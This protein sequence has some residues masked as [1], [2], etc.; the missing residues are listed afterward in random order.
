MTED[1]FGRDWPVV[2]ELFENGSLEQ[3][4]S[5]PARV[6]VWLDE[7]VAKA[8]RETPSHGVR[9][10]TGSLKANENDLFLPADLPG[11]IEKLFE[12]STAPLEL[13]D[14]VQIIPGGEDIKNHPRWIDHIL[15]R[16]N[17]SNLDRRS[18]I[19]AI[20]GGALLDAVG[21]AAALAHRGIRLI[22]IPTT[23]LAQADSGVGV[24]NAVNW[25]NKK[26][27]KGTFAVPW[28]VVNDQEVLRQLPDRDFRCGFSE[29]VKVSLLKSP[30][31]FEFLNR[32]ATSIFERSMPAA[33]EAIRLSVLMHIDH[34]TRGGD[35]FEM[36]QARPLD[37]GHW[38]AHKLEAL[39]EYRIRHGEAVSIGVAVDVVY[40][41]L[42]HGLPDSIVQATLQTLTNLGLPIYHPALSEKNLFDGLEEFRQHLGGELTLT[43]LSEI[44]R[45]IAVHAV[46]HS[47]MRKAIQIVG[48]HHQSLPQRP[49]TSPASNNTS[50]LRI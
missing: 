37:F 2:C 10:E 25:F 17:A 3:G 38:S 29:A 45:P 49:T 50:V 9:E 23:T 1:C 11:R 41:S 20:G 5:S 35:P 33:V 28:G 15:E 39:T 27:W 7:G 6:Q 22:R 36:L 47:A 16:I 44:G 4:S 43:M 48:R 30:I 12:L 31:A 18:Y 14:P 42:V 21:F 26:N 13:T 24:K 46:D 8:S 40:S 34:I 32:H 19:L